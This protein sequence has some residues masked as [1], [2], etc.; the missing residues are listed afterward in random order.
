[1]KLVIERNRLAHLG[2]LL[3]VSAAVAELL[4]R[5]DFKPLAA[6]GF[7]VTMVC[8]INGAI[9]RESEKRAER[10]AAAEEAA[11]EH[12]AAHHAVGEHQRVAAGLVEQQ[13]AD[14]DVGRAVERPELLVVPWTTRS[15]DGI[16][17]EEVGP[18]QPIA[19][20][21]GELGPDFDDGAVRRHR[22]VEGERAVEETFSQTVVQLARRAP[23]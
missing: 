7:A 5:F 1:M 3:S 12:A 16:E 22:E 8:Q 17:Q 15:L 14:F 21:L 4:Q 10:A 20:D 13:A 6:Y 18:L 19:G 9:L 23:T 2:I 11:V